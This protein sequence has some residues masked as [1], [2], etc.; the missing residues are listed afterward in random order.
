MNSA[1]DAGQ[2]PQGIPTWTCGECSGIWLDKSEIYY[3]A[4]NADKLFAVIAEAYKTP[5]ASRFL[6]RRCDAQ[7]CE[8]TF[9]SPGP[10]IDVCR[11]CGGTWF[12]KGEIVELLALTGE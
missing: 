5:T 11:K 7:M 4:K 2:G 6:C 8:V 3:Y 1:L 10:V 12:D 9:P